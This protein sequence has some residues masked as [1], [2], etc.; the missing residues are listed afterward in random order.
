MPPCPPLPPLR[1]RPAPPP[2]PLRPIQEAL[3]GG[4]ARKDSTSLDF[5]HPE[6]TTRPKLKPETQPVDIARA[7]FKCDAAEV[8]GRDEKTPDS[9]VSA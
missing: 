1:P 7:F 8:D 4:G 5:F 2:P 6:T 9:W 3:I